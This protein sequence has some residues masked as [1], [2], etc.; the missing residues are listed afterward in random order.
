[1]RSIME[2]IL[3]NAMLDL[4]GVENVEKVVISNRVVERIS[5][6]LVT[7]QVTAFDSI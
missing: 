2:G 3:L 5:P 6:A 7:T 1:M 4:P